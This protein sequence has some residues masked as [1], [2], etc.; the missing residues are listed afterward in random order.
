MNM[1]GFWAHNSALDFENGYVEY[2]LKQRASTK[3][4]SSFLGIWNIA[5]DIW[6]AGI[7]HMW[8][9]SSYIYNEHI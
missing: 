6:G 5:L 4:V 7:M 9:T 1:V 2:F 3:A 8:Y